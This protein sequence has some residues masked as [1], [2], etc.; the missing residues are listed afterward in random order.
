M[1][2]TISRA[3]GKYA[4]NV[5]GVLWNTFWRKQKTRTI[6]PTNW[7]V[8]GMIMHKLK[9]MC[10]KHEVI[11]WKHVKV[12]SILCVCGGGGGGGSCTWD[13]GQLMPY[14]MDISHNCWSFLKH[15]YKML[16]R[17]SI[18]FC[19]YLL[20]CQICLSR[21]WLGIFLL[22]VDHLKKTDVE[23]CEKYFDLS[24]F[25]LFLFVFIRLWKLI[26]PD[27]DDNVVSSL[28]LAHVLSADA[29]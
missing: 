24:I 3:T 27:I 25:C 12:I 14:C 13:G 28:S 11:H 17:T 8:R 16:G 4:C 9:L 23:P 19:N 29:S 26:A 7:K 20:H 22:R 10:T 6:W 5:K 15:T 1:S 18:E 21:T 2:L